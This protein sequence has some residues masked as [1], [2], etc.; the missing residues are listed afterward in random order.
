MAEEIK[1]IRSGKKRGAWRDMAD[2][3]HDGRSILC[4]TEFGEYEISS[5]DPVICC[6]VSKRGFYVDPFKWLP[7]PKPPTNPER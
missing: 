4:V 1:P 5:W 6:W 7:L 2:A 3:P